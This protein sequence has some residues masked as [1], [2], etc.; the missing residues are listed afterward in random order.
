MKHTIIFIIIGAVCFGFGVQTL[1]SQANGEDSK[2]NPFTFSHPGGQ[3]TIN[4]NNNTIK[5]ESLFR[6]KNNWLLGFGISGKAENGVS[7]LFSTGEISP[8]AKF[9]LNIGF[10]LG[11]DKI[12]KKIND[13]HEGAMSILGSSYKKL[14]TLFDKIKKKTELPKN[15]QN[16]QNEIEGDEDYK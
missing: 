5:I 1:F 3:F 13:L 2:G 15:Y 4:L 11:A 7:S 16:L 6:F 10:S 9:N 14:D 8:G 12:I